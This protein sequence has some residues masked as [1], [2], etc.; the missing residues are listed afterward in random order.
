MLADSVATLVSKAYAAALDDALWADFTDA[1][2]C[3]LGGAAGALVVVDVKD[4]S[5]SRFLPVQGMIDLSDEYLDTWSAF[6]P[7]VS[8]VCGLTHSCIYADTDHLDTDDP[9]TAAYE[10]WHQ[11]WGYKHY[12]TALSLLGTGGLRAAISIH[13]TKYAGIATSSE[14]R[15]LRTVFPQVS[16]AF[17][18]GFRHNEKLAESYWEGLSAQPSAD[19]VLLLDEHGRMVCATDAGIALT[20]ENDGIGLRRRRLFCLSAD[21]DTRLGALIGHAIAM[22]DASAGAMRVRRRSGR[23]P[24]I[25]TI[26]PLVRQRRMLAPYEAAALVTIT[27]PARQGFENRPILRQAFDLT[28]REAEFA[29]LLLG[30]H[31]VESA[32]FTLGIAMPTARIHVRNLLAKT[33]TTSQAGFM[34]VAGGL[35]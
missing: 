24:Y 18:L 22:K 27:D 21:D 4:Q 32:A 1:M 26:Y 31:S 20:A 35:R 5:V 7:Q 33:G 2:T 11:D 15:M 19:A 10:A 6:D 3:A 23:S 17:N 9:N 29:A 25:L 12:T 28:D 16:K 8:Q 30:G 34:R 14:E 13:K